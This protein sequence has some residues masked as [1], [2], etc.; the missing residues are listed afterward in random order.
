ME[1]TQSY[2]DSQGQ[3][4]RNW[5][6]GMP[7]S[8]VYLKKHEFRAAMLNRLNLNSLGFQSWVP[9]QLTYSKTYI[10]YIPYVDMD[11]F[12]SPFE[13]LLVGGFSPSDKY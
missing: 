4:D 6:N 7:V 10:K 9:I 11:L 1:P 5:K 12:G 13:A 3:T 8:S 2:A